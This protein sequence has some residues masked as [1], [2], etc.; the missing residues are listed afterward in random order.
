MDNKE[1]QFKPMSYEESV[2]KKE[3]DNKRARYLYNVLKDK[4]PEMAERVKND[5]TLMPS[6]VI[7]VNEFDKEN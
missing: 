3:E 6:D 1:Y 2:R 7:I 4:Y 5:I